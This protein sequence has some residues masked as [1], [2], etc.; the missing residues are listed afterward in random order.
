M[1]QQKILLHKQLTIPTVPNP[2][3]KSQI[4][5]PEERDCDWGLHYNP[6]GHHHHQTFLDLPWLSM[7]FYGLLSPSKTSKKTSMTFYD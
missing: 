2:S 5:S 6:T 1:I 4:Q 7:I 3:P